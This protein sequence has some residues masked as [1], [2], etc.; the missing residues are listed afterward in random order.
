MNPEITNKLD[1]FFKQFKHQTFKR[2]EIIVRA[3]ENPPGVF[4][5]KSGTVKEYT[6]SSKGEELVVNI[7]KPIS[8]FPM[9]W[10]INN[11]SNIFY[12]EALS[13]I[14]VWQAPPD[15]VTQLLKD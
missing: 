8:F 10:A 11:T 5:L 14:E 7:F 15:K 2:G 3:D 13:E 1:A 4:Y 12:Y 9:S 6:I